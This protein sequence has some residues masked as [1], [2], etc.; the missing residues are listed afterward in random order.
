MINRYCL[1]SAVLLF[2]MVL[3]PA[4]AAETPYRTVKDMAGREVRV[5]RNIRRVVTAGGTASLN[6]FVAALGKADL[7][8]N[9]LPYP[10]RNGR[11]KLQR[12][13]IPAV[14]GP[15]VSG[16]GPAWVPDLEALSALRHDLVLVSNAKTARMLERRGFTV[17]C[18][19]FHNPDSVIEGIDVLGHLLGCRERARELKRYYRDTMERVQ[20]ISA[21]IPAARRPTALF[22]H[23]EPLTLPMVG[24]ARLLI[25]RS[26][27]SYAA[28]GRLPRD[29]AAITIET[30][31]TWDP[32]VL[33]VL[34]AD[35]LRR[36]YSDI[37]FSSL[38]AVQ[39]HRVFIMP[40]G[41]HPWCNFTPEQA[42]GILWM[43]KK[44]YPAQ[45][46]DISLDDEVTAFYRRFYRR[47]LTNAQLRSI[48]RET[49]CKENR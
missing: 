41:L 15:V 16:A 5:P 29:H 49:P 35:D 12:I 46:A 10:M 14:G 25:E 21:G 2:V 28:T 32:D 11:W 33:F 38:R 18:L 36:A 27:G 24:T 1:L 47:N 43:A 42:V 9:G 44:L 40:M 30:L 39:Q 8:V 4:E 45:F 3:S 37:R 17:A 6:A 34:G 26:G 48:L 19:L 7:I 31:L 13:F 20:K 22:C 23:L